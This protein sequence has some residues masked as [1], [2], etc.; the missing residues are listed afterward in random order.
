MKKR[1]FANLLLGVKQLG[2]VLR[3]ELRPV[4]DYRYRPG[5]V[6][7]IRAKLKLSQTEFA[8]VIGV[9]PGTLRNWEQGIRTPKGPA[10][11]LLTVAAKHPEAVLDA[12][13][14]RKSA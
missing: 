9:P 1:D 5:T 3:G 2:A 4:C 11:A 7:K 10:R 8:H 14:G 6:K 13:H 12:L